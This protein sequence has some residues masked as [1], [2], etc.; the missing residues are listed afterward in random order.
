ME[1]ARDIVFRALSELADRELRDK[2]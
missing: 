1:R 2:K